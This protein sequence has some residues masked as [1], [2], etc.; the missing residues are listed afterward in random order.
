MTFY[1]KNFVGS[2]N[3]KKEIKRSRD[4]TINGIQYSVGNKN[5][6]Q[7]KQKWIKMCSHITVLHHIARKI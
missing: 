1:R 2:E 7:I 6:V 4:H 3:L 5:T